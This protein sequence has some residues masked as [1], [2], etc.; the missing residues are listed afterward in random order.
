[1]IS[2]FIP[3]SSWI[4]RTAASAGVSAPS[5]WP[6]GRHHS[7]RPPRLRRAIIGTRGPASE[8]STEI[9]PAEVSSRTGSIDWRRLVAASTVRRRTGGGLGTGRLRAEPEAEDMN[10]TLYT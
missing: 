10:V 1:M 2:D 6:L 4:S 3:V 5:K 9:P 7:K 8:L